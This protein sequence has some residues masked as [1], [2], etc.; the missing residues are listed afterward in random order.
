MKSWNHLNSIHS[1]FCFYEVHFLFCLRDLVKNR[2]IELNITQR[3]NLV[4]DEIKN[5]FNSLELRCARQLVSVFREKSFSWG[6]RSF[7]AYK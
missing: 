3:I 1:N 7:I 5:C 4:T 6:K 2:F